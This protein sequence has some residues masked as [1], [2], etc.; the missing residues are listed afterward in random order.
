[1]IGREKHTMDTNLSH[2]VRAIFVK[3]FDDGLIYR[4]GF[5]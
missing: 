4:G 2:A 1:M 5:S 3:L